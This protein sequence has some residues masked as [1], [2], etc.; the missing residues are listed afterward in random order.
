M[1]VN[2]EE[3]PSSL[4]VTPPD[5]L[6]TTT[7]SK[8]YCSPSPVRFLPGRRR[9]PVPAPA[10]A[11]LPVTCRIQIEQPPQ[12]PPASMTTPSSIGAARANFGLETSSDDVEDDDALSDDEG[13]ETPPPTCGADEGRLTSTEDAGMQRRHRRHRRRRKHSRSPRNPVCRHHSLPSSPSS[14]AVGFQRHRRLDAVGGRQSAVTPLPEASPI[15][16]S[17]VQIVLGDNGGTGSDDSNT[18]TTVVLVAAPM[19]PPPPPDHLPHESLPIKTSS[20]SATIPN[21]L[22]LSNAKPEATGNRSHVASAA[23]DAN[24]DGDGDDGDDTTD[25]M[26]PTTPMSDGSQL[27]L[28]GHR[29]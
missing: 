26:S 14:C 20:G 6:K 9:K 24:G 17:G 25:F 19:P 28:L 16:C 3:P 11:C 13:E 10:P 27:L 23:G 1:T 7:F 12:P 29:K 15:N 5:R 4:P 18:C 21:S 22:P 8:H 2:Q